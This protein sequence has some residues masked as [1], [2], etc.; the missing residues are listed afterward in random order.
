MLYCSSEFN[1]LTDLYEKKKNLH[2]TSLQVLILIPGATKLL[3]HYTFH[4]LSGR[5]TQADTSVYKIH[6]TS[7][8]GLKFTDLDGVFY[9]IQ[10]K[11]NL[12]S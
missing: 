7:I 8:D 3:E 11:E 1:L 4:P 5:K 2:C 10:L 9:C 12:K 6:L